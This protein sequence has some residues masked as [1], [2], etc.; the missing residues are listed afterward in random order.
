MF[1]ERDLPSGPSCLAHLPLLVVANSS[2]SAQAS[3]LFSLTMWAS[4][5]H[6]AQLWS[7]G[8]GLPAL[9]AVVQVCN[10][11]AGPRHRRSS[12]RLPPLK[13]PLC[14]DVWEKKE[15]SPVEGKTPGLETGPPK[16]QSDASI[17]RP[18]KSP[19]CLIRTL[20]ITLSPQDCPELSLHLRIP[21]LIPSAKSLLLCKIPVMLW[22][23]IRNI[24]ALGLPQ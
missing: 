21:N 24:F 15:H 4:C 23:I 13:A 11:R 18:G 9:S 5:T 8:H 16:V 20:V 1:P 2:T 3:S 17:Q 10:A 6:R 22:F 19:A 7:G 12:G 14:R